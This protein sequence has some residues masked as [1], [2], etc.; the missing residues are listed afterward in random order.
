MH[1]PSGFHKL[2]IKEAGR[3]RIGICLATAPTDDPYSDGEVVCSTGYRPIVNNNPGPM[4]QQAAQTINMEPY[5]PVERSNVEKKKGAT[6][7]PTGPAGKIRANSAT[8]P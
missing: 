6:M 2:L 1:W 8:H 7:E 4:T 5:P 3:R